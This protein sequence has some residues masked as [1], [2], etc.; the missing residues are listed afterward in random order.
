MPPTNVSVREFSV[1]NVLSEQHGD[2]GATSG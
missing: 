2:E 1:L